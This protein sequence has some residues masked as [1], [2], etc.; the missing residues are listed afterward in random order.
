MQK[1]ACPFCGR[2][3]RPLT[4]EHWLPENWGTYFDVPTLM[5]SSHVTSGRQQMREKFRSPFT[6]KYRGICAHCNNGWLRQLDERA[7]DDY[8]NLALNRTNRLAG[9]NAL[10]FA[11][12]VYRAALMYA[13]GNR[14]QHPL[15]PLER[16]REFYAIRTPGAHDYVFIGRTTEP[17]IFLGGSYSLLT[18]PALALGALASFSWCTDRL[19]VL[20]VVSQPG[21]EIAADRL[22]KRI[23]VAAQG[24]VKQVWPSDGRKSVILTG[25]PLSRAGAEVL[26]QSKHLLFGDAPLNR[27]RS[28][29]R[30]ELKWAQGRPDRFIS[31]AQRVWASG[32]EP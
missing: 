28:T 6:T 14:G 29:P 17:W 19:F 5:I 8:L 21:L 31:P 13:W 4:A 3:D 22:A 1:N 11:A 24:Q 25:P 2:S 23:K 26:S 32:E 30:A 16:M 20:V 10:G 27:P 7:Q 15:G 18:H 12:S 9:R